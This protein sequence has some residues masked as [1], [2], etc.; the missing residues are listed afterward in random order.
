MS[1]SDPCGIH[2]AIWDEIEEAEFEVPTGK[3]RVL[4]SYET[5]RHHVAYIETVGVG[6]KLP[7]M[8]LCLHNDIHIMVPLEPTYQATW[9]GSP[10]DLRAAVETGVIPDIEPE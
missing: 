3:D 4:V 10:E 9:E 5:G 6:D 7:E 8:P 2:K 1:T